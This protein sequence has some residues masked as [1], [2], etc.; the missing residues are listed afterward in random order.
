MERAAEPS[1]SAVRSTG[2]SLFRRMESLRRCRHSRKMA[3]II[4]ARMPET[5]LAIAMTVVDPFALLLLVALL[6][7]RWVVNICQ[8]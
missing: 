6:Q 8:F 5:P 3:K 1:E 4:S 7:G 2:H